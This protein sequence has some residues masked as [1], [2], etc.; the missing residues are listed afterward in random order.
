[1]NNMKKLITTFIIVFSLV[2]CGFDDSNQSAEVQSAGA[3]V[4]GY[5]VGDSSIF[6]FQLEL[7]DGRKVE[8]LH[9]SHYDTTTFD[10]N[11][12]QVKPK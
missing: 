9:Q 3:Y 4:K 1:M 6:Y 10:C 2:G 8:C 7:E 5:N 11:W 12:E